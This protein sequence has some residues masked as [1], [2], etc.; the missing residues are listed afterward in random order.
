MTLRLHSNPVQCRGCKHW[1]ISPRI[2]DLH[3]TRR[4]CLSVEAMLADGFLRN[5]S[6]QWINR[7]RDRPVIVTSTGGVDGEQS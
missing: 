1:F 4:G 2:H 3:V 6:G 5:D 7:R